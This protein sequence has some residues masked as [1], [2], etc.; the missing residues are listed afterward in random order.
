MPPA[1][2]MIRTLYAYNTWANQRILDAAAKLS[3]QQ[4]TTQVR[5]SF[6]SVRNTL[7]HIMSVQQVWLVRAQSLPNPPALN[8]E[9]YPTFE[10]VSDFWHDL[11]AQT[12]QIVDHIDETQLASII[13][14]V[15]NAG[16]PNAY[17]LWQIL[18][19]QVTHAQQHRSEIAIAL[20]EF[21]YSPG[22]LDLL[23]YI[24][25]VQHIE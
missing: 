9:D 13:R 8:F 20:T 24:D 14:Y 6:D 22:F 11:D 21:G 12:H 23:I 16:E 1:V 17:P 5:A 18:P 25:T 2:E 10:S 15:N 7:V 19:H 4:F 3:D